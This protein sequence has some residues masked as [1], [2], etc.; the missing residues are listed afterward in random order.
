VTSLFTVHRLTASAVI[1]ITK[2][3]SAVRQPL[4]FVYKSRR[5]VRLDGYRLLVHLT[6]CVAA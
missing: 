4:F 5:L 6:A 1:R 2:N 3:F